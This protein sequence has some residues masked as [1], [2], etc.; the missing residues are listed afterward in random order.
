MKKLLILLFLL[1]S[2]LITAQIDS[3]KT[4]KDTTRISFKG[5][6]IIIVGDKE[7]EKKTDKNKKTDKIVKK[8]SYHAS[9]YS[10]WAG[11]NTGFSQYTDVIDNLADLPEKLKNW[12]LDFIKS[13]AYEINFME[14]SAN[15]VKRHFLLT[16]GLGLEINRYS[17][18]KDVDLFYDADGKIDVIKNPVVKYKRNSLTATYV[19]VPFLMEFNTSKIEKKG[20]YLGIGVI[21]GYKFFSRTKQKYEE[22]GQKIKIIKRDDFNLNPLKVSATA[23]LGIKRFMLFANMGLLPLYKK[24]EGP[25][26]LMPVSFGIQ[27]VGF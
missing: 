22:E 14:Y 18:N 13:S 2:F 10:R 12:E 8:K 21:A 5:K 19:T 6:E 3:T 15:I 9:D 25:D 26:D 24:G 17:F 27:F 11:F 4:E 23:R 1:P 20:V 7:D 16:T